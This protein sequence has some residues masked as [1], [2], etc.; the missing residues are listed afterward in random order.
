M[1][2]FQYQSLQIA[3]EVEATVTGEKINGASFKTQVLEKEPQ[4]SD[5]DDGESQSEKEAGDD[6]LFWDL[7]KICQK[8]LSDQ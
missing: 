4:P 6:G 1:I 8:R 2:N 3:K 5:E 7:P